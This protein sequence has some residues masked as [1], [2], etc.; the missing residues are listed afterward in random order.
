MENSIEYLEFGGIAYSLNFV[1][2][3][4]LLHIDQS[5]KDDTIGETETT[6]SYD[7]AGNIIGTNV[8]NRVIQHGK[9][10][11][12]SKYEMIRFML[13]IV[14]AYN[15]ELDDSLGVQRAFDKLPISFKIAF[16]TLIK[17]GILQE[18]K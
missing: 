17:Y 7:A 12:M 11:D 13:E 10:I 16:N 1:A 5:S 14:L 15:E 8:T 6:V 2:F 3:D 9:E 18:I 4:N